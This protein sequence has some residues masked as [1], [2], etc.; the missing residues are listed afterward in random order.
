M[1]LAYLDPDQRAFL[2]RTAQAVAAMGGHVYL[3]GGGV[4]DLLLA[5]SQGQTITLSDM[6]LVLDQVSPDAIGELAQQMSRW[7]PGA[8]VQPHPKFHTCD[9]LW[10]DLALDLALARRETYPHPAANPLVTPAD[11]HQDLHRRDFTINAMALGLHPAGVLLD[12]FDGQGDLQRKSLRVLHERS[13]ADDPTRLWRGVRYG[14]RYGLQFAPETVAQWHATLASGVYE[15]WRQQPGQAPALQTRLRAELHYLWQM[16]Q[17]VQAGRWLEALGAWACIH[18]ELHWTPALERSLRTASYVLRHHPHRYRC[19]TELLVSYVPPTDRYA[20]AHCLDLPLAAQKRLAQLERLETQLPALPA[21]PVSRI[22]QT[23]EPYEPE[24][25]W[26]ALFRQRGNIRN[27]LRNYLQH[28]SHEHPP[29][30][31]KDLREL[32]YQPGPQFRQILSRLRSAY[33][34]REITDRTEAIAYVQRYFP[35]VSPGQ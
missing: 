33:L 23:L 28:W 2:T 7:R 17:W 15:Y 12:P 21:L 35:R 5:Q 22:C 3:V 25:L 30:N 20:V 18:P 10:P 8:L 27:I 16:A 29:L 1:L 6:D 26:L 4:R 11:I 14:V 34:D 24:L 19:L 32:G 13:F 31:G 9:L